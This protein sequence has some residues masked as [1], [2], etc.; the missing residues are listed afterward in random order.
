[1][2]ND[3]FRDGFVH[4]KFAH[5]ERIRFAAAHVCGLCSE[6]RVLLGIVT[7]FPNVVYNCLNPN[8][9]DDIIKTMWAKENITDCVG[10]IV[11]SVTDSVEDHQQDFRVGNFV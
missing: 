7:I 8:W 5:G 9:L 11:Q 3:D 10:G 6:R 4:L 1:M 2:K